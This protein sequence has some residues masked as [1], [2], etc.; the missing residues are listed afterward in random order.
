[1]RKRIIKQHIVVLAVT[2]LLTALAMCIFSE[3]FLRFDSPRTAEAD[4]FLADGMPVFC[5]LPLSAMEIREAVLCAEIGEAFSFEG[6]TYLPAVSRDATLSYTHIRLL[7]TVQENG[8]F[9]GLILTTLLSFGLTFGAGLFFIW[10][11]NGRDI[12]RPLEHLRKDLDRL[13]EG[14]L[15][16]AVTAGGE[17]EIRSLCDKTEMLRLRL[18]ETA[19]QARKADADRKFLI[20]SISHDLK[21]PIAALRGYLEGIRDG[22][23][24]SPEKQAA[25]LRKAMEKTKLLGDMIGELL[26][27]AKLDM[28]EMSI[29]LT[30]TEVAPLMEM[31]IT[32]MQVAFSA[33][34]I[35]LENRVP[36]GTRVRIDRELFARVVQNITENAEK[37]SD[38]A[39]KELRV[40]LHKTE[41]AVIFSF[42]DNGI[43][44]AEGDLPRVFDRFYRVDDARQSEGSGGLGL[45]IAKQITE[46][47]GGRI[48][49]ASTVGK[50][51]AIRISLPVIRREA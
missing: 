10:R 11:K 13:V 19:E 33:L 36:P 25:Y 5:S 2:I 12:T 38:K 43:G 22:V 41:A 16:V 29:F 31:L 4:I 49:A 32:E 20:S 48:W 3:I 30:E 8:Y 23:A 21:T 28:Q 47:M 39:E 15:S 7:P 45:A 17:A 50:G 51:T 42:A 44:I 40:T 1:M 14:E 9:H 27:F 46:S 35:T 34:H 37:Y 26:L 24:D 6:V 18:S